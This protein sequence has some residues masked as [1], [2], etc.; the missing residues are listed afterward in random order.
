VKAS[1]AETTAERGEEEAEEVEVEA[2]ETNVLRRNG[3]AEAPMG[4]A[5]R[6]RR[7]PP[8]ATAE[9]LP[10]WRERDAIGEA[11]ASAISAQSECRL[12]SHCLTVETRRLY[13]I[14][15]WMRYLGLVGLHI[16]Q[17]MCY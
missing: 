11:R 7:L 13:R 9:I 4:S 5:L 15:Y 6:G 10:E 16:W 17:L 14:H 2:D 12:A 1:D 3:E 8:I